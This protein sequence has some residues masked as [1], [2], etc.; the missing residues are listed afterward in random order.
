MCQSQRQVFLFPV[1]ALSKIRVYT[2]KNQYVHS[3]SVLVM[4]IGTH[5]T[6]SFVLKELLCFMKT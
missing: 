5:N 6:C 2:G 4:L 3:L 1:T